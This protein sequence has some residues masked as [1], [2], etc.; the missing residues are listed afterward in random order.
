MSDNEYQG[1]QGSNKEEKPRNENGYRE[2]R[3]QSYRSDENDMD[4]DGG[5]DRGDYRQ[6]S[7]GRSKVY[8]RRK[9]CKFCTQ[10]LPLDYKRPENLERFITARGKIL[11]RRI[12][13]T[14]AKHQR[15]L[16]RQ[17]KRARNI[18]FLPFVKR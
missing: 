2:R 16:A 18:A 12:T 4:D 6:G 3:S 17:V 13:G 9:V 15:E 8:F 10:N 1:A 5:R 14:C 7:R 11:P